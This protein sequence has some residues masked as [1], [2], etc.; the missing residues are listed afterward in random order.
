MNNS[1]ESFIKIN[2]HKQY[3]EL[4]K[5]KSK[6]ANEAYNKCMF[7][8]CGYH[9]ICKK[10]INKFKKLLESDDYFNVKII[11]V[12]MKAYIPDI[13]LGFILTEEEIMKQKEIYSYYRTARNEETFMI[14]E[15]IFDAE[16]DKRVLEL[17]LKEYHYL[18][19]DWNNFMFSGFSMGSRYGIH[20]CELLNAKVFCLNIN[21]TFMMVY[22]LGLSSYLN[23]F[24][25]NKLKLK[26]TS[27]NKGIASCLSF[28]DSFYS[29]KYNDKKDIEAV[30]KILS[31]LY[32]RYYKDGMLDSLIK[33]KEELNYDFNKQT[34]FKE[35]R[36]YAR[37]TEDDIIINIALDDSLEKIQS[38]LK[39]AYLSFD[40]DGS[41]KHRIDSAMGF[42]GLNI[43]R[44]LKNDY[45][46]TN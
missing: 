1:S 4:I 16:V 2:D 9:Q 40:I 5:L 30:D 26:K 10:Y 46:I 8:F 27:D 38:N 15:M 42:I 28:A 45:M 36:V 6:E 33:R 21:K 34:A 35:S 17:V 43:K 22:Y 14:E 39:N 13:T 25:N 37:Y 23:E 24:L 3:F 41:G 44:L 11:L 12:E 29:L 7:F 18:N 20:L 31:D 19:C 32:Y